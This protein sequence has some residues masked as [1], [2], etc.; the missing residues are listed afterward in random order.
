MDS[1]GD[2]DPF[3]RG[4]PEH[5]VQGWNEDVRVL[6][7]EHSTRGVHPFSTAI[8]RLTRRTRPV[9]P[10]SEHE[11]GPEAGLESTLTDV[12][13]L[14]SLLQVSSHARPSMDH[15]TY[16]T[17]VSQGLFQKLDCLGGTAGWT[18]VGG[19]TEQPLNG[20]L[21]LCQGLA[22]PYPLLYTSLLPQ[23]H[24]GTETRLQVP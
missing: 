9:I 11:R 1:F 2:S 6:P 10:L 8:S 23:H 4:P 19:V 12:L 22:L 18:Y 3:V 5:L 20:P 21:A 16:D 24:S 14:M 17:V 15:A 13:D 7:N